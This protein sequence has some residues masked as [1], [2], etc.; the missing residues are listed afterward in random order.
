MLQPNLVVVSSPSTL[1]SSNNRI[2]VLGLSKGLWR[3][4]SIGFAFESFGKT[5]I[6]PPF[7]RD[8]SLLPF[9]ETY[10]CCSSIT[11]E[12]LKL[13]VFGCANFYGPHAEI[14]GIHLL[15]GLGA[16]SAMINRKLICVDLFIFHVFST[17]Q[18]YFYIITSV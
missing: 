13:F 18:A 5:P 10:T 15:I 8:K 3:N 16:S 14:K 17:D 4:S 12:L 7:P 1:S 11:T 9:T 6:V 2:N